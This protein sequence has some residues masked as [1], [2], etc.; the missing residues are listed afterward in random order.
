MAL[1]ASACT[2]RTAPPRRLP[3]PAHEFPHL[4]TVPLPGL[5]DA[6]PAEG[7]ACCPCRLVEALGTHSLF[8][9]PGLAPTGGIIKSPS[10]RGPFGS[11]VLAVFFTLC[12][13]VPPGEA[14][15]TDSWG[16]TTQN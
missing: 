4:H 1:P 9:L 11:S 16:E 8:R 15:G 10:E 12:F 2:G 6:W 7:V 14:E 13:G 3:P 5:L